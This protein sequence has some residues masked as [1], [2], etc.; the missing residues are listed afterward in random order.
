MSKAEEMLKLANAMVKKDPTL[1]LGPADGFEDK[2][3]GAK[4]VTGIPPL[5][6]LFAGGVNKGGF[7]EI[8][9][10]KNA[11]KTSL[12]LTIIENL[13]RLHPEQCFMYLDVE[14]NLTE[15]VRLDFPGVDWAKI[16]VFEPDNIE[17]IFKI[18]SKFK[19]YIDHLFI[20]SIAATK[21]A[22]LQDDGVDMTKADMGANAKQ[23]TKGWTDAYTWASIGITTWAINQERANMA[24]FSNEPSLPGGKA[25]GFLKNYEVSLRRSTAKDSGLGVE[26]I[27]VGNALGGEANKTKTQK[28]AFAEEVTLTFD[29]MKNGGIAK[30]RKLMY[31]KTRPFCN[32]EP[33]TIFSNKPMRFL[34]SY[35]LLAIAMKTPMLESKGAYITFYNPFNG[36][37][38]AKYLG[39]KEM[40]YELEKN[41]DQFFLLT[42]GTYFY[43][44]NANRKTGN[45]MFYNSFLPIVRAAVMTT[46]KKYRLHSKEEFYSEEIASKIKDFEQHFLKEHPL[47]EIIPP[48][49]FEELKA[50]FGEAPWEALYKEVYRGKKASAEE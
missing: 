49:E 21:T 12:L 29:K 31:I 19:G 41:P 18:V 1:R 14:R 36:N 3:I 40:V 13:Q 11:G 39:R 44:L 7:V 46:E 25:L 5:D 26:D 2:T 34:E 35:N 20:D 45:V 48:G 9:A 10:D 16:L 42:V 37:E 24:Q 38:V 15:S 17:E 33:Y 23:Y 22:I 47:D 27:E 32:K 4:Y 8:H 43:G 28:A 30:D 50:Q 6:I